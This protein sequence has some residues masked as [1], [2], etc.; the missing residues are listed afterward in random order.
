MFHDPIQIPA[1]IELTLLAVV[2]IFVSVVRARRRRQRLR[3]GADAGTNP[4]R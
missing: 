4:G 1:L 2:L 3:N